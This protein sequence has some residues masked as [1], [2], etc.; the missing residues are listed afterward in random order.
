MHFHIAHTK[1][2]LRT[3]SSRIQGVP[4]N[5]LATMKNCPGVQG[6]LKDTRI[7]LKPIYQKNSS[8]S[9]ASTKFGTND[10]K[11]KLFMKNT[12][13]TLA[14]KMVANQFRSLPNITIYVK[15]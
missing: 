14:S 12:I 3:T 15:I 6:N 9:D 7:L 8:F 1:I 2:F 11:G 13:S 4:I 5:N 10:A